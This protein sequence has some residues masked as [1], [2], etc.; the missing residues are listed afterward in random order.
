MLNLKRGKE[1]G[2]ER[3]CEYERRRIAHELHDRVLQVLASVALRLE[4]ARKFL[5]S[6]GSSETGQELRVS[7]EEVRA[8][9]KEIRNVLA[10]TS[11]AWEPGTLLARVEAAVRKTAQETGIRI[12]LEAK[13]RSL[14]LSDARTERAVFFA[15]REALLNVGRHSGATKAHINIVELGKTLTVSLTDDGQGFA[16]NPDSIA[17]ANTND[18]ASHYGLAGM[19]WRI[20]ELGGQV[21]I[22]SEPERGTT[23]MLSVPTSRRHPRRRFMLTD[24]LERRPVAFVI[25]GVTAAAVTAAVLLLIPPAAHERKRVTAD[26]LDRTVKHYERVMEGM[27]RNSRTVRSAFQL[28]D[29]SPWGYKMLSTKIHEQGDMESRAF[30]Y[31]EERTKT[32]L[33]AEEFDGVALSHEGTDHVETSG[34][35]YATYSK[36]GVNTVAWNEDGILCVLTSSVPRTELIRLAQ[37]M[38]S[39]QLGGGLRTIN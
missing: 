11:D 29:L 21:S 6:I 5:I 30:V 16:S 14:S 26:I 1:E 3:G 38:T 9:M 28:L 33:V 17:S 22:R 36:S 7:E 39:A 18:A 23:V 35:S 2:F 34:R 15:T 12:E 4:A 20:E 27:G 32:L 31:Q 8:S 24:G 10:A 25:G 19:A 13:P 37:R